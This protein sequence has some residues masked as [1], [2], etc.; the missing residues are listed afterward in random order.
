VVS[1]VI[2]AVDAEKDVIKKQIQCDLVGLKTSDVCRYVEYV[3]DTLLTDLKFDPH[4]G[5]PN[6]YGHTDDIARGNLDSRIK[7]YRTRNVK[8]QKVDTRKIDFSKLTMSDDF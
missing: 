6:P 7:K 4:Y 5:T 3:A 1:N 2:A 8:E